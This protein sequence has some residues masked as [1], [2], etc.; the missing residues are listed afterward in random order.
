LA[1][2]LLLNT[3]LIVHLL[4]VLFNVGS[5]PLILW[6]GI[7]GWGW[8]KNSWFRNGHVLLILFVVVESLLGQLCPL[9]V[10][11]HRLRQQ[12]HG[13]T[14]SDGFVVRLVRSVIYYDF[15]PWVFT[16]AYVSFGLVV[17][18]LY[19]VYPPRWQLMP[20]RWRRQTGRVTRKH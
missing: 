18:A 7:R 2:E 17:I 4:I 13:V 12:M 19:L 14:G 16:A 20:E 5:V 8:I 9:T 15:E 11:E 3:I 10:L 1:L 6:G